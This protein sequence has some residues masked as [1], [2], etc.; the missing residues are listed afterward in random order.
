MRPSLST[1]LA[2]RSVLFS[3]E[4]S[5]CGNDLQIIDTRKSAEAIAPGKLYNACSG[6]NVGICVFGTGHWRWRLGNVQDAATGTP[7]WRRAHAI[8]LSFHD[9]FLRLSV[10][11]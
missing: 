9:L 4:Y 2:V 8:A 6:A 5:Y 3:I 7:D 10:F 11:A 1:D